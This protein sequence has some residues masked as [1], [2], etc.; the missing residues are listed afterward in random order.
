[1]ILATFFHQIQG[2]R[3]RTELLEVL[4]WDEALTDRFVEELQVMLMAAPP[5][6]E[7]AM[8]WLKNTPWES[9]DNSLMPE[10][11]FRVVEILISRTAAKIITEE[12]ARNRHGSLIMT[13]SGETDDGW[14]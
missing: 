11:V 8:F 4:N 3:D 14:N 1:M 5:N 7:K 13:D 12:E 6:L 10:N 9:F 2:L